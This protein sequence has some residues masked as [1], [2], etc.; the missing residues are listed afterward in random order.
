MTITAFL[1][2][3]TAA[4]VLLS[5]AASFLTF[6]LSSAI[7]GDFFSAH[8]LDPSV[9]RETVERLRHSYGLDQPFYIQYVRWLQRLLRL[10]LGYSLLYQRPVFSIVA[11]AV[12]NTL[13]LG[14]PALILGFGT[15]ILIG[16]VHGIFE[17]R[18]LGKLLDIIS[19][20]ALSLPSLVLGMGGLLLAAHT[21][22]FPL[23]S[24]NSLGDY[25]TGG[26]RWGADRLHHLILPVACLTIP[27]LAYVERIQK[28][29]LIQSGR[30]QYIRCARARGLSRSRI[31]FQYLVRPALNPVLSV[32]GPLLG[33]VLSGSLVLEV[34]FAWPG[35]GQ[36]TYDSLFNLD[37][38]LLAGCVM[39]SSIL[40][41][42]GNLLADAA[43]V[44]LD[45]RTRS[46]LRK[47]V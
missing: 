22:W 14:I 24:M 15:G 5:L 45:P 33:G 41:V 29:G 19:T 40:L 43:L 44:A 38:L 37:I 46:S 11:S 21:G 12:G 47:G 10:D 18:F 1:L 28:S 42:A 27:V 25:G 23:G 4:L 39:A 9:S 6:W 32:A 34:I 13:W 8:L 20:A 3:R 36:A 7:P 26:M 17:K 35:L 30:E 16:T 2:K 31:L